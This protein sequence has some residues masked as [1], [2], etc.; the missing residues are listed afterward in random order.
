MTIPATEAANQLLFAEIDERQH[1]RIET[2]AELVRRPSLLGQELASASATARAR[3]QASC[4]YAP[5]SSE[6]RDRRGPEQP[7]GT[8]KQRARFTP[9]A[10]SRCASR[11]RGERDVER[12][13][14][15]I[16]RQ[17]SRAIAVQ[18]HH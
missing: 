15:P 10:L 5:G 8:H 17:R 12:D 18:R 14:R 3:R 1:E 2:V 11:S 6:T 9:G 7:S 13:A 16:V 4:W